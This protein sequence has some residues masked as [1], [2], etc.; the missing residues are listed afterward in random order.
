MKSHHAFL[1]ARNYENAAFELNIVQ[2]CCVV[3][4]ISPYAFTI[5]LTRHLIDWDKFFKNM[6]YSIFVFRSFHLFN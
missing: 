3:S 4:I 6:K 2:S 1:R 5:Q